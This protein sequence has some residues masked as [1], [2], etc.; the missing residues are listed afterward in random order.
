MTQVR[1]DRDIYLIRCR[2]GRADYIRE[3]DVAAC[4]RKT[5]VEDIASGEVEHV[6][7]VY[8]FNPEDGWARDVSED[9]A[10]DV[11]AYCR[12][13]YG[14]VPSHVADFVTEFMPF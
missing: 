6:I 14:E 8:C 11:L 13:R 2:H 10:H 3:R 1:T 5:T 4:D 7:A 12:D 9:I